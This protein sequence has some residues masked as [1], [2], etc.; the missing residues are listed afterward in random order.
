[1]LH[2]VFNEYKTKRNAHFRKLKQDLEGNLQVR[3][4]LIEE[5]K[6]LLDSKES[7]RVT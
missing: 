6:D 4:L 3:N 2:D 7:V 5:I 1:M